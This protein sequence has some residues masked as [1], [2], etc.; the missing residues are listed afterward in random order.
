MFVAAIGYH[1]V[2]AA[3]EARRAGSDGHWG[4]A[5]ELIAIGLAAAAL[6]IGALVSALRVRRR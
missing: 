4:H 3:V 5:V 2:L 6:V 1:A